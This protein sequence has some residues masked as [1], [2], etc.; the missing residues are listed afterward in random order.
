MGGGM[1][2]LSDYATGEMTVSPQ[3]AEGVAQQ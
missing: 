3:E 1:M 2:G